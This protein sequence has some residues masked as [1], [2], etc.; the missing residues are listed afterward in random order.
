MSRRAAGG[1][2]VAMLAEAHHAISDASSLDELC[3][4]PTRLIRQAIRAAGRG[5]SV[6]PA[7]VS[8]LES[9]EAEFRR[10]ALEFAGASGSEVEKALRESDARFRS[11]TDLGSDWYWEQDE[12]LRFTRFEGRNPTA[13]RE[14]FLR[15]IGHV[16][17]E[18][19]LEAEAGWEG[20]RSAMEARR[21]FR[22]FVHSRA[23]KDG[24]RRWFTASGDPVLVDGSFIGYRGVG[25]DITA[26]KLAEEQVS[27]RATHDSLTGLPNRTLFSALF[28]R[29]LPS[30]ARNGRRLAVLFVDLD[31]FKAVN[32]ELGHEAGDHL[33]KEAA[34]RFI[35]AVRTSDVVA[36][37]GGDEFGILVPELSQKTDLLPIVQRVLA[38]AAAPLRFGECVC[39]VSA[40]IGIAVYPEDGDSEQLLMRQADR[41][42]YTAKREG[43]NRFQFCS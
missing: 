34:Q 39:H 38:A 24:S 17:W 7:V 41:A 37:L 20:L 32:D 43:R 28:E 11:L 2:L 23:L 8:L 21:P 13:N 26:Q 30:A 3:A 31:G 9:I 16:V 25:R 6:P 33:L 15:Y 10:R 5:A 18:L 40:S 4:A 22:D 19:G 35:H 12:Q 1:D 14:A 42:M 36:R 27:H 29:A